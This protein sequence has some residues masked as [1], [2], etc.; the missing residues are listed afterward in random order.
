MSG[1]GEE[2]AVETL[3]REQYFIDGS[4]LLVRQAV[5]QNEQILEK[6]VN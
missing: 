1:L 5:E 4:L 3:A 6:V 2:W